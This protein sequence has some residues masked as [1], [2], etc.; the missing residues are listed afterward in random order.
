[1]VDD[2]AVVDSGS[3]SRVHFRFGRDLTTDSGASSRRRWTR[4]RR[5]R[6]IYIQARVNRGERTTRRRV[7]RR[8]QSDAVEGRIMISRGGEDNRYDSDKYDA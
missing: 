5:R 3:F 1:M 4:R 2:S 8:G 7:S 6:R